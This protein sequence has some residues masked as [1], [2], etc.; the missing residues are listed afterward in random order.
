MHLPYRDGLGNISERHT[1]LSVDVDTFNQQHR[2]FNT[3]KDNLES[4]LDLIRIHPSQSLTYIVL[5]PMTS[6]ALMMKDDSAAIIDR[7]GRFVCM[8]GAVDVPGN[9]SPSA[10]CELSYKPYML[11]MNQLIR[12]QLFRRPICRQRAHSG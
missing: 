7:V 1:E 10:E 3:E 6:L 12:S 8:G 5:G 4:L 9:T 2:C 11:P